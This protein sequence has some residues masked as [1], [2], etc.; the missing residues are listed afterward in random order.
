[1]YPGAIIF[2]VLSSIFGMHVDIT[3]TLQD[4]KYNQKYGHKIFHCIPE[5]FPWRDF[6]LFP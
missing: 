1:M 4:G 5:I 6:V 2:V 3:A